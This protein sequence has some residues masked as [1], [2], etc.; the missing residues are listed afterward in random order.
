[1]SMVKVK[2]HTRNG[3]K[4]SPY[5][6]SSSSSSNRVGDCSP[7]GVA[8]KFKELGYM[9]KISPGISTGNKLVDK[10]VAKGVA[11]VANKLVKNPRGKLIIKGAEKAYPYV[12]NVSANIARAKVTYNETC[13][14]R[15]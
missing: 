4:V 1:M 3:S 9:T 11:K 15:K 8:K 5:T 13:K 2:S 14:K 12:E 6:R 10:V 7:K